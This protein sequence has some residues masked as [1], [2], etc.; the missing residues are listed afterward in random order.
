MP[1]PKLPDKLRCGVVDF[2]FYQPNGDCHV[3]V[4]FAYDAKSPTT[5]SVFLR[6]YDKNPYHIIDNRDGHY[7]ACITHAD[8]IVSLLQRKK[9]KT[10]FAKQ[11]TKAQKP[12]LKLVIH[13]ASA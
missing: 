1:K 9:P 5:I 3:T 10:E 11:R 6:D 8:E 13:D 4:R 12:E 7:K 2:D